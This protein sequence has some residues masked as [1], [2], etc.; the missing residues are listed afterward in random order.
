MISRDT[1]RSLVQA[2]V[3][4][5]N[6]NMGDDELVICDSETIERDFGW[7]FIYT[8]KRFLETGDY[9]HIPF[10][11]API[12]VDRSDGTLHPTGTNRPVEEYIRAYEYSKH[13]NAS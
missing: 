10:G 5:F 11:N 12:I 7:V 6:Q 4:K 13:G 2:E 9:R 1:A 8:S 3:D